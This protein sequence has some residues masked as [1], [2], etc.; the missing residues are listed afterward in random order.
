[1]GAITFNLLAL[2][3]GSKA[4]GAVLE[5]IAEGLC[6]NVRGEECIY[7]GSGARHGNIYGSHLGQTSFDCLYFRGGGKN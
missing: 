7:S 3:N 2:D 5:A 6:Q 4:N 1:M